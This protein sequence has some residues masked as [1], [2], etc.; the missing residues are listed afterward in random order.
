MGIGSRIEDD[1]IPVK[2]Y[3]LQ[4]VNE[5]ALDIALIVSDLDVRIVL[6]EPFQIGL[7]RIITI[8]IRLPRAEQ[9]EVGPVYNLYFRH[10]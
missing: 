4:L 2:S 5:Q 1:A 6:P 3:F 10:G 7:K 8:D 9:I